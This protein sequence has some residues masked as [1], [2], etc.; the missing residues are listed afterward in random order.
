MGFTV[1][2]FLDVADGVQKDQFIVGSRSEVS[3]LDDL[4]PI[5][6]QLLDEPVTAILA[7]Q[8]GD[9]R[10][11]LTPVWFGHSSDKVLLELRGAPEEDRVVRAHPQL[12]LMLLNPANPYHWVSLKVT[13]EK[14]IKEDDP[15]EGHLATET[16][17][18]AWTKY[19]GA[20][21]PY[22]LRDPSIDERRVLFIC[23]ID[24]VAT[25]GRP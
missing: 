24:R 15:D 12:T 2:K 10:T 25:F 21:P 19:T 18:A 5:Y 16:I 6:Q 9:G 7:V 17:D 8:G 13:V 14:E 1:A 20:E 22:G 4:D 3:S 23:R 11:N